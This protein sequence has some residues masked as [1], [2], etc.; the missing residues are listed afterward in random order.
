M[1]FASSRPHQRPL[2]ELSCLVLNRQNGMIA[3]IIRCLDQVSVR[4]SVGCGHSGTT[5][6][7]AQDIL[8]SVRVKCGHF[9]QTLAST[10]RA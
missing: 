3:R 1:P 7:F 6:K 4:V 2:R 10:I 8:P 9:V 5:G